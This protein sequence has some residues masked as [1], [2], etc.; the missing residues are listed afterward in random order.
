MN[1]L[2]SVLLLLGAGLT[3]VSLVVV[4]V[5]PTKLSPL[6]DPVSQY[7]ITPFR[8]WYW[9]AA[10]GAAIAGV[11]GALLFS[12]IPGAIAIVTTVLLGVF[13]V[14]RAL[15]GVFPMDAPDAAKSRTG[16]THNLLAFAAFASVTAAAFTGA[17]AIHD[18]GAPT[19]STW[20]TIFGVIMAL[21][22]VGM[23]LAA[24]IPALHGVFGLAERLIY[25]GF[26][27]WFLTLGLTPLP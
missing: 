12:T 14:A 6:R 3:L 24:A 18:A 15:I 13:A 16:R 1:P 2:A 8:G 26:I 17:G 5:L 11:G 10:G 20:S 22:T 19:L 23:I 9:S 4:H 21:G 7:G 25:A 27:A